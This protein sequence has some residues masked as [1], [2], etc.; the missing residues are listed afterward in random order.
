MV[1]I[2]VITHGIIEKQFIVLKQVVYKFV[3][4]PLATGIGTLTISDRSIQQIQSYTCRFL[5]SNS[6]GN[7]LMGGSLP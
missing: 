1:I 5:C 4:P 6:L 3:Y 7:I 2:E